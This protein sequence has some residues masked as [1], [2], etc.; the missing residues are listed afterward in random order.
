MGLAWCGWV[1]IKERVQIPA[2]GGRFGDSIAA[3]AE[4][5]PELG[6]GGDV[7][8]VAALGETATNANQGDRFGFRFLCLGQFRLKL[9]NLLQGIFHDRSEVLGL[10]RRCHS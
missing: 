3:L 1:G 6:R 9:A 2:V 7:L 8:A 4:K 5:F 10:R